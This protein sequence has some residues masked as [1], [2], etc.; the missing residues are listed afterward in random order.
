MTEAS[1]EDNVVI[2]DKVPYIHYLLYFCKDKKNEIWALIDF[3]SKVYYDASI[4]M[5]TLVSF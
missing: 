3:G 5:K 4:R 1:K 2:L